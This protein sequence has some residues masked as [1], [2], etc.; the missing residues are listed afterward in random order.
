MMAKFGFRKRQTVLE[1]C[2]S[3]VS[4]AQNAKKSGR[5]YLPLF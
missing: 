3:G 1:R 2:V 4:G 5:K